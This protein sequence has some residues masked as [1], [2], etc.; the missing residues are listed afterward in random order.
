MWLL[1][2]SRMLLLS[3]LCKLGLQTLSLHCWSGQ[4]RLSESFCLLPLHLIDLRRWHPNSSTGASTRIWIWDKQ[5]IPYQAICLF[6]K[7]T[8]QDTQSRAP[9]YILYLNHDHKDVV[10]AIRGLSCEYAV[11]LDNKLRETKFDGGRICAQRAVEDEECKVLKELVVK[12]PSFT[13][14]T[15]WCSYNVGFVSGSSSG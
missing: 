7:K 4:S 6:L 9:A 11:L 5:A 15:F 8:Y 12:Y 13:C 14:W 3:W 1:P 10:V 2:S